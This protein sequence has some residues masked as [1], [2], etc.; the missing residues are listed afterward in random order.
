MWVTFAWARRF[1][2]EFRNYYFLILF[3]FAFFL[4]CFLSPAHLTGRV[5]VIVHRLRASCTYFPSGLFM[6]T[7]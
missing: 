3:L 2:D 5:S 7:K 6:A 1:G 4:L